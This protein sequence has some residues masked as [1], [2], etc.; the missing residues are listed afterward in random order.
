[1]TSQNILTRVSESI[2]TIDDVLKHFQTSI[3]QN[4]KSMYKGE[5]RNFSRRGLSGVPGEGFP[6]I[7]QFPGG[8]GGST[9]IFGCFNGQNERIFGP[10]GMA[11]LAYACLRPSRV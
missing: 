9:P 1:M 11:P 4:V 8:W 3:Q 7:F 5:G 10:G 2:E 6:A